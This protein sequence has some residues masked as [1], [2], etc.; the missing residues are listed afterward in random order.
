MGCHLYEQNC[1]SRLLR[2]MDREA[3]IHRK[4]FLK[5]AG[6]ALAGIFAVS[7]TVRSQ[8]AKSSSQGSK[9]SALSSVDAS[10]GIAVNSRGGPFARVRQAKGTVAREVQA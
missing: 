3:N 9:R 6:L 5:R 10:S 1:K 8:T 2:S 4:G 7:S